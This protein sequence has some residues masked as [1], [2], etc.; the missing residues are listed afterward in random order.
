MLVISKS[1]IRECHIPEKKWSAENVGPEEKELRSNTG[2]NHP[3]AALV[4][5]G[6]GNEGDLLFK[7]Q[8]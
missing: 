3:S 7:L 1:I 6:H 2:A 4:L 5:L 8:V